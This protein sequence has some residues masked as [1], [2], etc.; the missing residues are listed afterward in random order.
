M[1]LPTL[2]A[3]NLVAISPALVLVL[4]AC[5][6]VIVDLFI[7]P[8]HKYW[9]AWLA[10][11][12][13]V[14]SAVVLALQAIG[15]PPGAALP[16]FG[17]ML[18]VDGFALFLQGVFLLAA[19]IGILVAQ[20]YLPRRGIERGEYYTLL[21]FTTSGMVFMSMAADLIVVF[22]ALELL[23]IPLYV[24]AGFARPHVKSEESAMKYFL[25]GAFASGFLVYGIALVYGGTQ[26][27]ALSGI[28]AALSGEATNPILA[29]IGMGLVLVGLGFKVAAVPFHMWTPDVYEGAPTPVT[30]FMSVGAKAGGFAALL[31]VLV[32]AFPEIATEWGILV[33]IIACLTMILGNVVAISQTNIKRMLAYSSIAHAGY[34]LV[35]VAAAQVDPD[36]AVTS[37]IFYLLAYTFTN[38]GAFA[39]A[40]AVERDDGSGNQI[41]DFAGLARTRP[42]IAI[43]MS[44]FMFSLIGFP[45]S[46]GMIGKVFVFKAGIEAAGIAA[47][48]PATLL[49]IA[50]IVGALTSL[51][52]AFY[53][54]RV[55]VVMWM[56]EGEGAVT[57]RLP[58]GLALAVTAIG[59]FL[60]GIFPTPFYDMAQAALL[61]LTG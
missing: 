31:R 13:V 17:G 2:G 61:L 12:L 52:S 48:L 59:T 24:L 42:L 40:I 25:L 33:S 43:M 8:K 11:G 37:A 18:I 46:A 41:D 55:V 15:H 27:T 10:V 44:L 29:F 47:P 50:L 16:V 57:V 1:Q 5:V 6:L 32:G 21:L 3:I 60:L 23:S 4:G 14:A 9:T 26:T 30:A 51:I 20:N 36:A 53:Y 49:V 22:L 35:A 56:R 45:P 58:L 28:V 39:V 34:I 7:D 19:F 54:L 38:L